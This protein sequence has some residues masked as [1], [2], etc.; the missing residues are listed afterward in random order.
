MSFE[1]DRPEGMMGYVLAFEGID[2]SMMI[3]NGPTGC[4]YY[5]ASASESSYRNRKSGPQT[6]NP[7]VF[8]REFFFNQ[9]RVLSTFMDGP[10]YIS[11]TKGKLNNAIEA[12]M[13]TDPK[14]IGIL[15]S[16][17]A[18]LIGEDLSLKTE[19]SVPVVK[20]ESPEYSVPMCEGFQ[21]GI[22]SILETVK[23][24]KVKKNE[25]SGVNL[26]G[27]S[28]WHLGWV[29]SISDLTRLLNMCDITVNMTVGAGWSAD[30]IEKSSN[31]SLNVIIHE[32][33]GTN[34]AKWYE[35]EL[36]I[37]FILSERVPIGFDA[38]ESWICNI[39]KALKKDPKNALDEIRKKRTRAA[40]VLSCLHASRRTPRGRSFSVFADGSTV[41][42]VTEFLYDY[43]GMV[44]VATGTGMD[45][46]W[47]DRIDALFKERG[48]SPSE[49]V[50]N[51][52]CDVIIADG[53]LISSMMERGVAEGG[54]A[55]GRPG[56]YNMNIEERPVLGLGGTTRLLDTVLNI[57]ER[58]GQTH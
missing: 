29:D 2:D 57:L 5:P 51:T 53:N 23:P 45:T 36:D 35:S 7:Y 3:L 41:Y 4:K 12:V 33:F 20:I 34:I 13:P 16:P 32:E 15:N 25:R 26:L 8:Q 17:G 24:K 27:I 19:P 9:P 37:P 30:D 38:L 56:L 21:N 40:T 14:L 31:A 48:I 28:V 49:D 55:I 50:F 11:G 44:P 54:V 39:C 1:T 47:N 42:A 43:L 58:C 6:F 46:S 18:S 10:D 52:P 22:I